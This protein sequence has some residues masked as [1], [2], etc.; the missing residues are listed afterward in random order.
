V[1][2]LQGKCDKLKTCDLNFVLL[3]YLHI[4]CSVNQNV[5]GC[6]NFDEMQDLVHLI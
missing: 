5:N 6:I 4:G 2:A 3:F 1:S